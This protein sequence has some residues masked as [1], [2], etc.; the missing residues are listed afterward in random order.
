VGTPGTAR[1]VPDQAGAITTVP[2]SGL[3]QPNG[4]APEAP[5]ETA[6]RA[7]GSQ[8]A[9]AGSSDGSVPGAGPASNAGPELVEGATGSGVTPTATGG[10]ADSQAEPV[11]EERANPAAIAGTGERPGA[12][13]GAR[14]AA[15][16][17]GEPVGTDA[18]VASSPATAGPEAVSTPASGGEPAASVTFVPGTGS[19]AESAGSPVVSP[20]AANG[21]PAGALTEAAVV[22][23][24]GQ[25][26]VASES[27]G[28]A[29][30][31]ATPRQGSGRPAA[32]R[33]Q[34]ARQSGAPGSS[35]AAGLELSSQAPQATLR[36]TAGDA[37]SER[38]QGPAGPPP[39]QGEPEAGP[40]PGAEPPQVSLEGASA[41]GEPAAEE[42]P[43]LVAALGAGEGG[44]AEAGA[45]LLGYGVGLQQA[46][47]TVNASIELA[48]RSGLAQARIALEPEELGEI[49]I[50]LTQTSSGLLARVTAE[51]PAAA[52]ALAAGHVE[53]RESLSSAG[54]S[55]ARLQIGHGEQMAA[56]T[57]EGTAGGRD[58]AAG[59]GTAQSQT[60]SQAQSSAPGVE[61]AER[62]LEPEPEEPAQPGLTMEGGLVDVLA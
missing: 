50:H 47:E 29:S 54:L 5:A 18:P 9:A 6:A 60:R 25:N 51:N 31:G 36:A 58:G 33:A 46:I 28:S 53:L 43:A 39:A 32:A 4:S 57:G 24:G 38:S 2:A 59:A 3:D 17:A 22:M 49:R 37:A 55:L 13:A 16:Q 27:P 48:A 62:P 14:S 10:P 11:A 44:G 61:E 42:L 20:P 40:A 1:P 21:F 15:G 26:A 8:Q 35:G 12:E 7:I 34:G 52:Q 30:G 23:S 19:G 41:S 56:S 45:P